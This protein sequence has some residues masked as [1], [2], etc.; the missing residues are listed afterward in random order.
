LSLTGPSSNQ[1]SIQLRDFRLDLERGCGKI[2]EDRFIKLD[3]FAPRAFAAGLFCFRSPGARHCTGPDAA[4]IIE[5]RAIAARCGPSP[6]GAEAAHLRGRRTAAR[7]FLKGRDMGTLGELKSRVASELVR[8]DQGANIAAAIVRAIDHYKGRRFWFNER[9]ATAT[10]DAGEEYLAAPLVLDG[11]F[12]VE[13][14]GAVRLCEI[15]QD[16]MEDLYA[17]GGASQRPSLFARYGDRV[18]VYPAPDQAYLMRS[19]GVFE[20]VPALDADGS[21]NVWTTEA[22]DL[23]A[24]RAKLMVARD[25]IGSAERAAAAMGAEREALRELQRQGVKKLGTGRL[26]PSS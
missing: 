12:V 19:H 3:R 24:A 4:A 10:L 18:R 23:I 7:T 1:A 16:E 5:I 21:A 11:L 14:A 6:G 17:S 20:M 25:V 9:S 8:T 2:L 22:A 26:R 13:G 15:G